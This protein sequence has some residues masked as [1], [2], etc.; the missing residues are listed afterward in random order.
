MV[1]AHTPASG[2]IVRTHGR[3]HMR[4]RSEAG[5]SLVEIL[6]VMIVLAILFAI[7]LP[8]I[9]TASDGPNAPATAIA[10]GVVWRGVQMARLESGGA[11]PTTTEMSNQAAGLLDPAGVRRIRPWPETGRGE[12]IPIAVS[13]AVTPSTTG[14]PNSL[15][16]GVA[17]GAT[18][19]TGWLVGYGPKGN[20]VFR[21]M[22]TN[23]APNY[24]SSAGAP[25][26]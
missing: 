10:A 26:G 8:N 19:S 23:G 20:I 22:I 18:P 5:F 7:A 2:A 11:M 9:R 14:P 16:Y 25:A 1:G 24:A 21:R 6:I 15:A 17:G 4:A 3:T 12:P 13:N